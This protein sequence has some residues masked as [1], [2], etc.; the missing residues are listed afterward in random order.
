MKVNKVIAILL[1]LLLITESLSEA[2]AHLKHKQITRGKEKEEKRIRTSS[3]STRSRSSGG[4]GR[5]SRSS[6]R[7]SRG[8]SNC[9]PLFQYLFRSCGQW[10][11][12]T[13]ISPDNP[14]QPS[15]RSS[16]FRKRTPPLP[17][18]VP[19]PPTLVLYPPPAVQPLLVLSPPAVVPSP[20]PVV[21]S[22][23]PSS[24]P[25]LSLPLSSPP[26]AVEPP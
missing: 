12:P 8:S 11:F 18:Q 14:F 16:P 6:G 22:P 23:P 3:G 2:R 15:P 25:S 21:T 26:P 7:R 1:A 9:D 19:Y 24:L 17:P 5:Q 20:P 13:S 10:P 4:S